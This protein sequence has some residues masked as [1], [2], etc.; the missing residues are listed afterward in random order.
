MRARVSTTGKG[1]A[2]IVAIRARRHRANRFRFIATWG[3]AA[4]RRLKPASAFRLG[5]AEHFSRRLADRRAKLRVAKLTT[6]EKA[7]PAPGD[8]LA[9]PPR[10]GGAHSDPA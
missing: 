9:A 3:L 10:R 4:L 5:A 7:R 6:E 2:G 8:R 1:P